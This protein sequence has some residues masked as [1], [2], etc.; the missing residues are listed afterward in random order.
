MLDL[1]AEGYRVLRDA[2]PDHWLLAWNFLEALVEMDCGVAHA[3]KL[4]DL[5]RET[6]AKRYHEV[7]VTMGL[8]YLGLLEP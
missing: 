8:K 5:M 2:Y 4:K 3:C 6:E 1:V 7:P